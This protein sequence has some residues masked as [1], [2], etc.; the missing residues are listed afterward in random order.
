MQDKKG[1][2]SA[3]DCIKFVDNKMI[4]K[5]LDGKIYVSDFTTGKVYLLYILSFQ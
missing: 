4:S 2:T 5:S 1:H 3:V